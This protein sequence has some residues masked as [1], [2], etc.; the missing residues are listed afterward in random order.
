MSLFEHL[1]EDSHYT[2][3]AVSFYMGQVV[4]ALGYIHHQ[5]IVYLDIKVRTV[6]VSPYH[7]VGA[8]GFPNDRYRNV[9]YDT[10]NAQL[11][12]KMILLLIAISKM[13]DALQ[14]FKYSVQHV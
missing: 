1:C 5:N 9:R 4:K 14:R 8:L 13:H 7:V 11:M 10:L 12:V 3:S 2:E 6:H